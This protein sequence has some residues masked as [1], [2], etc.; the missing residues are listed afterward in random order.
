MKGNY[1]LDSLQPERGM[2]QC[3]RKNSTVELKRINT[4]RV[5]F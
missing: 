3:E 5:P 2:K 4:P 1:I